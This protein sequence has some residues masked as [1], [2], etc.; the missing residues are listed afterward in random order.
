MKL[1]IIGGGTVGK[2]TAR[3]FLEHVEEVRVYD[4]VKERR[5][6][7]M[8]ETL[9]CDVVMVCL[10]TPQK[11][12]SNECDTSALEIFFRAV[13]GEW[14]GGSFRDGNFVIRSTVPVGFTKRM[15]AEFGLVNL[16]H[17]PEF[18]TARCALVDAQIPARNVVG[19]PTPEGHMGRSRNPIEDLY[20]KRWPGTPLHI[21]SSNTSEAAKLALNAFFL[22]KVAFFNE[23]YQACGGWGATWE[24]V[25]SI[26]VTDGRVH[27]SHTLVP[28]PDGKCGAG[29]HCLPKDA[30]SFVH[31]AELT[32]DP[33]SVVRAAIS[34]NVHDRNREVS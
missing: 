14:T 2:A 13:S 23:V 27:P 7:T 32:D 34:R 25:H 28:G 19:W 5:T 1:G 4:V 10:P 6:H 12:G 3:A 11:A 8:G 26:I 30:A 29:G 33:D 20:L 18:L 15:A 17:S 24:D 9:K 21:V 31:C 22:T 16:S